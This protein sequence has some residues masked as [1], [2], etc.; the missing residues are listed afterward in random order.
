MSRVL[1]VANGNTGN[2]SPF[3]REQMSALQLIGVEVVAYGIVGKGLMGYLRNVKEI[4]KTIHEFNPDIIHA[5]YG[6][7][8]LCANLQRQVPVITTYHGSDIHSGGWVLKLSQ[9]AMRLSAYNVFVSQRLLAMSGC[10]RKETA[11]IPCGVTLDRMSVTD[12]EQAK[13]QLGR[14]RSFVLF[15]GAFDNVI[16]N[17]ALA[18]EAMLLLEGVDL[19]ELSGYTRHE[20]NV[21]MNAADCLLMTSLREGSPQVIKEAMA[22]GTPVVSVDVGDVKEV[23][24]NTEGCYIAE[25]NPADIA[26]KIKM[27]L[28]F[29][30]KTNGRQRIIELGLSNDVVA[31]RL[32]EVYEE[33]SRTTLKSQMTT[34]F[35]MDI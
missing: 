12:R 17:A 5:H 1:I 34:L 29:K 10:K 13:Q 6:L 22:C 33:I 21:L 24:G 28:A 2:L 14:N 15:A 11:V 8:G 31:K 19:V 26:A 20:V 3:V 25:R 4:R 16:K 7:S 32:V 23:I 30:G 9:L 18:K 27:A 35:K